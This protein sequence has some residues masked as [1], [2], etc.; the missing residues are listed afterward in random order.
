[1][2]MPGWKYILTFG[3]DLHVYG[4]GTQRRIVDSKTGRMIAE[5]ESE[6]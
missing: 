4:K 6:G 2:T 1:M 5:Y 3:Y